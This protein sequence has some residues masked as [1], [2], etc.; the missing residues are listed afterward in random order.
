MLR[1]AILPCDICRRPR[2]GNE[3]VQLVRQDAR[4]SRSLFA[5]RD[6]EGCQATASARLDRGPRV[7]EK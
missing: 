7:V 3:L 4:G 6:S 5:C 2:P 1:K